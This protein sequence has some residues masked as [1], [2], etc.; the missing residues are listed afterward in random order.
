[1]VY[2]NFNAGSILA[3]AAKVVSGVAGE[4]APGK[5]FSAIKGLPFDKAGLAYVY[6]LNDRMVMSVNS[7]DGPVGLSPSDLLGLPGSRGLGHII[8]KTTH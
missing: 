7:E 8:E 1:M 3:P 4:V 2:Q 6:A 5:S